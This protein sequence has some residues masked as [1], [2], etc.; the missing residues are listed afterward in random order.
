MGILV[1]LAKGA[2]KTFARNATLIATHVM[3]FD[4]MVIVV[5]NTARPAKNTFAVVCRNVGDAARMFAMIVLSLWVHLNGN[6]V[7]NA[8]TTMCQ[9]AGIGAGRE[10]YRLVAIAQ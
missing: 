9:V 2:M 8:A 7:W 5:W 10:Q 6:A 1:I 3:Q 4:V